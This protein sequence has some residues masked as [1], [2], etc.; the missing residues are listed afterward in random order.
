M[1]DEPEVSAGLLVCGSF[2]PRELSLL[3]GVD[4]AI[5][6]AGEMRRNGVAREE[7]SW[8]YR[9]AKTRSFDWPERL[10]KALDIVRPHFSDFLAFC[11]R[12]SLYREIQLVSTMTHGTPIGSFMAE[13]VADLARLG[14]S[15]DI[16]LY[17][18]S[19]RDHAHTP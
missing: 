12:R 6:R 10:E 13:Q 1:S 17:V 7:D 16:D 8:H 2:D 4:A 14:C 5:G 15:L 18:A 9:T 3:L 19:D 11:D